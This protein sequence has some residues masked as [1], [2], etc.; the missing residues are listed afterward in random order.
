MEEKSLWAANDDLK[1]IVL[2]FKSAVDE[3]IAKSRTISSALENEADY[4]GIDDSS[5]GDSI[6]KALKNDVQSIDEAIM[7]LE[8][9]SQ[10]LLTKANEYQEY[11]E[12]LR[13]IFENANNAGR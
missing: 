6:K 9:L 2:D 11:T 4:I 13:S 12:K 8:G 5:I 7:E 10:S 3:F 1:G